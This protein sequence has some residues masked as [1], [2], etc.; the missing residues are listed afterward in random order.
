[1]LGV[2]QLA[3]D[4]PFVYRMELEFVAVLFILF[5]WSSADYCEKAPFNSYK[6]W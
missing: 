1:M 2:A 4:W 6:Y 5:A 3:I